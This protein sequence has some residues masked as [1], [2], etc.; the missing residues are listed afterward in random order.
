M[1]STIFALALAA[2]TLCGQDLKPAQILTDSMHPERYLHGVA[3][4]PGT[5][6][7]HLDI[8]ETGKLRAARAM[9]G[10]PDLVGPAFK[11]LRD[12]KFAP[13]QSEGKPFRS[14]LDLELN[15]RF[16]PSYTQG[17]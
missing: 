8:D 13:A 3:R 12:Y 2:A 5:V 6:K 15:F 10:R 4:T 17:Q 9:S 11:M 16:S 14:A 1:K 7:L